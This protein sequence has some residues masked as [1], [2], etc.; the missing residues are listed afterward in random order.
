M[1]LHV[2]RLTK[3]NC[4]PS[5]WLPHLMKTILAR[6][7]QQPPAPWRMVNWCTKHFSIW[8]HFPSY[9][10]QLDQSQQLQKTLAA[11][12]SVYF[13]YLCGETSC[14]HSS[15]LSIQKH[16]TECHLY[17]KHVGKISDSRLVSNNVTHHLLRQTMPSM[18]LKMCKRKSV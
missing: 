5:N 13:Y 16:S 8:F 11:C 15:S 2:H 17:Y 3:D 10:Q 14:P 6:V 18:A 9:S 7:N 1:T 12:K 4:S